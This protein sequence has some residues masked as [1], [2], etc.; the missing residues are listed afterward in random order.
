[1]ALPVVKD[2]VE[3]VVEEMTTAATKA[4]TEATKSMTMEMVVATENQVAKDGVKIPGQEV[5][6]LSDRYAKEECIEDNV[7][8]LNNLLGV[9]GSEKMSPSKDTITAH[10]S[11]IGLQVRL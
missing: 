7:V 10:A 6:D 8:L 4:T 5:E 9:F 2:T 1:M 11:I 3:K